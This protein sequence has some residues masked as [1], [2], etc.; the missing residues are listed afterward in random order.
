MS[1]RVGRSSN[2]VLIH[3]LRGLISNLTYSSILTNEAGFT[4]DL[5]EEATTVVLRKYFQLDVWSQVVKSM[6]T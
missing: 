4:I 1:V 3:G 6:S 5:I 2:S